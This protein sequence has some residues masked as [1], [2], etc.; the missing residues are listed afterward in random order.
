MVERRPSGSGAVGPRPVLAVLTGKTVTDLERHG[1]AL[2]FILGRP[3]HPRGP[4]TAPG[5]LSSPALPPR[6]SVVRLCRRG[7]FRGTSVYRTGAG[8]TPR[9]GSIHCPCGA[10]GTRRRDA[11]ILRDSA[12]ERLAVASVPPPGWP[13]TG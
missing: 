12:V 6:P 2:G 8:G 1:Q 3:R 10:F 7:K 5:A 13:P 11:G 9:R 4:S